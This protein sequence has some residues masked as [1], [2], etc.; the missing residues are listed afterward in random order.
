MATDGIRRVKLS[1]LKPDQHNANKGTERGVYMLQ[2]S[3]GEYGAGRSIL[4]DRDGNVIAGNKTLQE[5]ADLG[6]DEVI[7]VPTDGRTLVAVQREDLDL[8][9]GDEARLLAYADN[10]A[11][12]VG[13]EWDAEQ[14]LADMEAGIDLDGMFGT[15]E[16]ADILGDLWEPFEEVPDAQPNPRNLPIDV[17][18]TLQMADCTCCLAVQAGLKYGIQSGQYRLC[19]YTG[20]L[21]GRHEVVFIDND[22]F[23]YDHEA[24]LCAVRELRPKYATVRDVMTEAQCRE[25]GIQYYSLEQILEWAAELDEYAENVIVIPKYDCIDQIPEKYMLGY[26]VPTSHGGTPLSVELFRGRRVHLLGGSWRD[27]LSYMAALGDDVVS[28]D[29]NHIQR[30]AREF[31][32]YILPEGEVRQLADSGFGYLTNAR[33]AALALSF[34][35][36]GAKI[37]ELYQPVPTTPA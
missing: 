17:I 12:Q 27:Q 26:S 10:R 20:Q 22:Y 37:N 4:V 33:Y 35:A 3:L 21:S 5:A 6:F 14:L 9:D 1:E 29:N 32:N 2:R 18:Y 7:V 13:L 31:G 8:Y 11:S 23:D 28:V 36:M 34:G 24:H 16:L 30:I 25:A 15:D 19:P